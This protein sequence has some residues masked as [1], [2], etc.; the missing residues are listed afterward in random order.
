VVR[1]SALITGLLYSQK[2]FLVLSPVRDCVDPRTIV[3]PE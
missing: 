3:R 2:I 1:L